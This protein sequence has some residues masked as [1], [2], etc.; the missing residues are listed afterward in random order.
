MGANPYTAFD[1]VTWPDTFPEKT[2]VVMQ[3]KGTIAR[4]YVS[5]MQPSFV[6][7][8]GTG[9]KPIDA[10]GAFSGSYCYGAIIT[11][12]RVFGSP[13]ANVSACDRTYNNNDADGAISYDRIVTGFVKGSGQ[14]LRTDF[15]QPTW[16]GWYNCMNSWCVRAVSGSQMVMIHPWSQA[17]KLTA[18]PDTILAG[19]TVTFTPDDS[20]F[21]TVA[22]SQ[23][24]NWV[25]HDR[26]IGGLDVVEPPDTQTGTCANGATICRV[27]VFR[28]GVM[29]LKATLT[30]GPRIEQAFASVVVVSPDTVPARTLQLSAQPSPVFQGDTVV[31]YAKSTDYQPVDVRTWTWEDSVGVQYPVACA[32]GETLCKFAPPGR[33]TMRVFARVG[34]NR[35]IEEA[36]A[37]V[38]VRPLCLTGLPLV[39]NTHV[40][41]ALLA[42]FDS[43]GVSDANFANRKERAVY[44]Y[45][46]LNGNVVARY[47]VG[48]TSTNCSTS[49]WP[50]TVG[51]STL[52]GGAHSHPFTKGD[53]VTCIVPN[54]PPYTVE[55]AGGPSVDDL[56]LQLKDLIPNSAGTAVVMNPMYS[57][58]EVI[59][60]TDSVYVTWRDA[61]TNWKQV[62]RS[63]AWRGDACGWRN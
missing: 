29:Y 52:L 13:I 14:V 43:S 20:V 36:E 40:R 8:Q 59:I 16:P 55:Y 2:F 42:I 7:L 63:F 12:F 6:Y 26:V 11:D 22:G 41:R 31:F 38:P 48:E 47:P 56:G 51:S 60:D 25:P 27:P 39:D 61:S 49:S 15:N 28:T 5:P 32:A 4:S 17:L 44:F 21:S 35:F 54:Q 37:A 30:P 33:G 50:P 10:D 18:A 1:T 3:V 53:V 24:W 58:P 9:Y 23:V 57:L 45:R 62:T 19:D 46:L 34:L